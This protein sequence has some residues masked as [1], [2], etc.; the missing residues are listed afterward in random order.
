[1]EVPF[2]KTDSGQLLGILLLAYLFL[3]AWKQAVRGRGDLRSIG[4][5]SGLLL[6]P[7]AAIIH[8][9]GGWEL[10]D[11][12][13]S[14]NQ[15]SRWWVMQI[16][17]EGVAQPRALNLITG[18]FLLSLLYVVVTALVGVITLLYS[19]QKGGH[20]HALHKVLIKWGVVIIGLLLYLKSLD[21]SLT[22][23]LFGMGAASIVVG[24]AL[25]ETLANLFAGMALDL[26]GIIK[27]GEWVR[28]EGDQQTVGKVVDKGWRTT[29]LLTI[30][31][32]LVTLP[33]RM[34]GSQK[35]L[36][37][38]RPELEHVHTLEV[39]ASTA[40]PPIKVKEVLRIILMREP[41]I[42]KT[43]PPVVRTLRY[44]ESS[45]DYQ[46]RFWVTDYGESAHIKDEVLTRIWYAFRYNAIEIPSPVRSVQVRYQTQ[47][48]AE[49]QSQD[50]QA[51]KLAQFLRSIPA[52]NRHLASH[53]FDFLGRNAFQRHYQSG[54]S[55]VLKG[56]LGD[57]LF[58]VQD[59]S[60]DVLLPGGQKTLG[61][62]EYFGEMGLLRPG[63]R[64]ADVLA[65][66]KGSTVLRIDRACMEL[67][68]RYY[69]ALYQEF[70]LIRE[71]RQK[72]TGVAE[73]PP[74]AAAEP[75]N[76]K[77]RKAVRAYFVPW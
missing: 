3:V 60:C 55:V 58:I 24:L 50:D 26:E 1:M 10:F 75:F 17:C 11:Q 22:P 19:R 45:I 69:P 21:I 8:F 30:D 6:I 66:S 74:P 71:T 12:A 62:G 43:P 67:F 49:R 47:I 14:F 23:L 53:D 28:I 54:E 63:S 29:R 9:Y 37:F 33:N 7:S 27:R 31:N 52:L 56:T 44:N 59:G 15:G 70:E 2:L 77:L 20:F 57:A 64:G 5:V 42:L 73:T 46:L 4:L 35:I 34:V 40:D 72:E 38:H 51:T 48:A 16:Q 65:G 25:Q 13:C 41:R 39:G 76:L 68:F 36:N 61:P 32:E 18:T